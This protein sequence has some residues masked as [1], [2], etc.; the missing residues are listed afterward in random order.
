[1]IFGFLG[2]PTGGLA[3][4]LPPF[5]IISRKISMA[6]A[7]AINWPNWSPFLACAGAAEMLDSVIL[8]A[9]IDAVS[10]RFIL[11]PFVWPPVRTGRDRQTIGKA[12]K[13]SNI[14]RLLSDNSEPRAADIE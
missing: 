10:F 6:I 3:A 4:G 2:L 7:P 5:S 14:G 1:M 12:A 11:F 8:I 13:L 9:T